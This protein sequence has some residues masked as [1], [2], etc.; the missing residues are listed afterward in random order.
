[1]VALTLHVMYVDDCDDIAV[2][3]VYLVG[4]ISENCGI[5]LFELSD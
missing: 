4:A 5:D 3:V 1:M 2:Q